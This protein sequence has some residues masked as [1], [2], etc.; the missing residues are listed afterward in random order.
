LSLG[1]PGRPDY[2]AILWEDVERG[3]LVPRRAV[4]TAVVPVQH[5]SEG[6]G[7]ESL[8]ELAQLAQT[9]VV[10]D[11]LPVRA[12]AGEMCGD[13]AFAYEERFAGTLGLCG[14]GR[15]FDRCEVTLKV[16]GNG[17]GKSILRILA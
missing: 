10:M 7:G 8:M 2:F 3:M 1:F 4:G 17:F 16:L 15:H 12:T 5:A 14:K 9:D 13:A 11:R 6:M